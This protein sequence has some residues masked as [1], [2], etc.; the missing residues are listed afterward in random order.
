MFV[1]KWAVFTLARGGQ[2]SSSR[3]RAAAVAARSLRAPVTHAGGTGNTS[4]KPERSGTAASLSVRKV[5]SAQDRPFP[6]QRTV[7][8][9]T[10]PHEEKT[11]S[12]AGWLAY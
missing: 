2:S 3:A 5:T 11:R 9:T 10:P 1:D 7:Q 6:R 12:S 8:H 4:L